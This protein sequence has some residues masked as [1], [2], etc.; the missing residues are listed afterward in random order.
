MLIHYS[1]LCKAGIQLCIYKFATERKRGTHRSLCKNRNPSSIN[2]R[3]TLVQHGFIDKQ[4][5]FVVLGGEMV[6]KGRGVDQWRAMI[7]R[8][9]EQ[10]CDWQE[11]Q[12]Y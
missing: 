4:L 6:S 1:Y 9:E 3:I 11:I 8:P 10:V 5:G 2:V 12:M 7:E